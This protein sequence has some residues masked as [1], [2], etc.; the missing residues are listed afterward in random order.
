VVPDALFS[1]TERCFA[2]P[3]DLAACRALLSNGSKSF[4]AA[5][6][7][8]P[9]AVRQPAAGALCLLPHRR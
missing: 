2:D 3:A 1:Q 4:H 6:F 8:L 9:K 5:S 7:F